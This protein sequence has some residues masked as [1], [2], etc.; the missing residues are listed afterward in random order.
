[1]DALLLILILLLVLLFVGGFWVAKTL[2]W[3]IAVIVLIALIARFA[4]GRRTV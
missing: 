1:M 4:T 2:L 3:I